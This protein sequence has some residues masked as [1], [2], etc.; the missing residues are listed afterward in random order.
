MQII[1]HGN[2]LS[3][4]LAFVPCDIL[5]SEYNGT[6]GNFDNRSWYMQLLAEEEYYKHLRTYGYK[7]D[8]EG[9]S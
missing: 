6:A 2:D 1:L 3:S 8:V 5:P 7:V 4:L 9:G